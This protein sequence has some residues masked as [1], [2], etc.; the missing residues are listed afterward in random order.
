M[1]GLNTRNLFLTVQET[2]K[3][4]VK[5]PANS[6]FGENSTP[7]LQMATLVGVHMTFLLVY[8][9]GVRSGEEKNRYRECALVS[10][11]LLTRT[12]EGSTLLISINFNS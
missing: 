10:L 8:M 5:V 4:K 2:G 3:P 12:D 11:P 9:L 6:V 7:S 1:D